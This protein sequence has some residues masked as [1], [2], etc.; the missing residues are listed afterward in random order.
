MGVIWR[1]FVQKVIINPHPWLV[2]VGGGFILL[3]I[4]AYMPVFFPGNAHG[5]PNANPN[6]NVPPNGNNNANANPNA[7][8]PHANQELPLPLHQHENP[9]NHFHDYNAFNNNNMNVF[10]YLR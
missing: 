5:N 2:G 8:V 9:V 6:A 3:Q 10:E 7:N 4:Q 1:F